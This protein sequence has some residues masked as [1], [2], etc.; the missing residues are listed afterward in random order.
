MLTKPGGGEGGSLEM[1]TAPLSFTDGV[2]LVPVRICPCIC[3]GVYVLSL[4]IYEIE[5]FRG[6]VIQLTIKAST[7]H[8]T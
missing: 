4:D 5:Q 2:L 8:G 1:M 6:G 7:T 3:V